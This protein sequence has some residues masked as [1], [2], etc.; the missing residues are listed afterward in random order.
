M[1]L[2]KSVPS[3]WT[4]PEVQKSLWYPENKIAERSFTQLLDRVSLSLDLAI[5]H[6]IVLRLICICKDAFDFSRVFSAHPS[7]AS[8]LMLWKTLFAA[9][10]VF[11][12]APYLNSAIVQFVGCMLRFVNENP[13]K[14][15]MF[16]NMK[17]FN[18]LI[19]LCNLFGDVHRLNSLG[20]F[21]VL[22]Q[23]CDD[24][25]YLLQSAES[26]LDANALLNHIE[27]KNLHS[28]FYRIKRLLL[29]QAAYTEII[30]E[31]TRLIAVDL[32]EHFPIVA[33][34][35]FVVSHKVFRLE[36]IA[37]ICALK[38]LKDVKTIELCLRSAHVEPSMF[39]SLAAVLNNAQRLQTLKL[40][41]FDF[42]ASFFGN[43]SLLKTLRVLD[44]SRCR[45]DSIAIKE[46]VA[47]VRQNTQLESFACDGWLVHPLQMSQLMHAFCDAQNLTHISF[48]CV[49]LSDCSEDFLQLIERRASQL[50]ELRIGRTGLNSE[51][52]CRLISRLAGGVMP[53]IKSISLAGWHS[54]SV[55]KTPL[56]NF[57][58]AC[59]PTV[60]SINFA[61]CNMDDELLQVILDALKHVP[62][63]ASVNFSQNKLSQ[64]SLELLLTSKWASSAQSL[65]TINLSMN[66]ITAD[67][68]EHT[69]KQLAPRSS[70]LNLIFDPQ[71]MYIDQYRNFRLLQAAQ[72]ANVSVVVKQAN[73]K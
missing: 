35:D 12:D 31:Q 47:F 7:N 73:I 30:L 11:C 66:S 49:N 45:F 40:E 28:V 18:Q 70:I 22:I 32:S 60:E 9:R 34:E 5:Y 71:Q 43:L 15:H 61:S 4:S 8:K 41:S 62:C 33:C 63:L 36:M 58:A 67:A 55:Y 23:E 20:L 10:H 1:P 46:F 21:L 2:L 52:S 42:S 64:S 57:L 3:V 69:L 54:L 68:I 24:H 50:V 51:M 14:I 13:H 72:H 56:F 19:E 38:R 37:V 16:H 65:Q 25:K 27:E 17:F 26:L 39:S 29:R 48:E 44:V 53:C 6:Q 59:A